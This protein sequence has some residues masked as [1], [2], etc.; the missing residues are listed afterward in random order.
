MILAFL[1][2]DTRTYVFT[3]YAWYC[4]NYLE[5]M[6]VSFERSEYHVEVQQVNPNS[7]EYCTLA[8]VQYYL[9]VLISISNWLE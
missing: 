9:V 7:T 8:R 6:Q 3:Y 4:T 1:D 2:R 5:Y